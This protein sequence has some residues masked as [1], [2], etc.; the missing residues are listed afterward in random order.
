[1]RAA[2]TVVLIAH[3]LIHLLGF[4]KAF[5]LAEL[6]QLTI[7]ISR[8]MGALWLA[9]ALLLL[10]AAASLL[11]APQT[12][13]ILGGLA[14]LA[15]QV[16]I[17]SSWKDA[18]FGTIPNLILLATAIYAAFA[19]GPFGL[20]AEYQG[21]SEAAR[22]HA[23]AG[24]TITEAD[25]APLPEP[26]ARYLRYAGVVGTPQVSAFRARM[27][28]RIRG[29][30]EAPWMSFTAEQHNTYD[31]PRR[32]FWMEATRGGL[33]VDVLHVYD[34]TGASMRVRLLSMFT[35][36][37]QRGPVMTG[38]ET[39][40]LLNDMAI[41]APA[42]L[43]E[44]GI[45]WR[46]VDARSAEAT[47]TNGDHTVRATL[48]VDEAGALVDFWSD[49]RPSLSADGQGFDRQ[50]W[51]TPL[52]DYAQQGPYRLATAGEARYAAPSGAYAYLELEGIEVQVLPTP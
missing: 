16:A 15:S 6:P 34:D 20:R 10:A 9:A 46:S 43:L 48:V 7:P 24:A 40:T 1:M 23:Q 14:V 21:L 49:D 27:R 3:G 35:M 45:Q 38:A 52:R 4:A 12:F 32:S 2:F 39:V 42:R 31:P 44:P 5:G 28:G 17:L 22:A 36:V 11:W 18:R 47:F 8:P 19:W 25:L 26:I 33:P 51:S 30:A 13:W 50:R 41:L 37:E 29:A